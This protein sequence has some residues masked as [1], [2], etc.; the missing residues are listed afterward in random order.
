MLILRVEE[1]LCNTCP[2]R[3]SFV[4]DQSIF[5]LVRTNALKRCPRLI[6]LPSVKLAGTENFDLTPSHAW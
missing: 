2:Y 4:D 5:P 6:Y 3:I 1:M